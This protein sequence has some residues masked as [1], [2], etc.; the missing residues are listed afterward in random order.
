VSTVRATSRT[1]RW[2]G[3]GAALVA[4]LSS[5]VS[6][7]WAAGGTAL[8]STV[9][10]EVERLGRKGGTAVVLVLAVT[11]LA[12]A[13]GAALAVALVRPPRRLPVPALEVIALVGG[14]LLALYGGVL[15][16]LG[17]VAATGV[18]G[19]PADRR[20]LLWHVLLW[21]PWF[22]VW[23]VLLLT[24]ATARRRSRLRR[25]LADLSPAAGRRSAGRA[26]GPAR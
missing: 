16:A 21:D 25:P 17:A 22:L 1:V 9:G 20:A 7:Y 5:L 10:G 4:A 3:W 15:T 23:G 24:A 13:V 19:P 14:V 26:R 2:A 8:L 18:L 11:A 12:K 6:A